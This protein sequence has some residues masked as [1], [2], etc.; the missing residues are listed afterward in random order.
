MALNNVA[1]PT[2]NSF[3]AFVTTRC[4]EVAQDAGFKRVIRE[5]LWRVLAAVAQEARAA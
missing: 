5:E 3:V 4:L 2:G 1:Q